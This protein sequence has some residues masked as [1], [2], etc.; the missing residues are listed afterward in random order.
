MLDKF[1]ESD[2][3]K[4]I[5]GKYFVLAHLTLGKD[6]SANPGAEDVRQKYGGTGG[7]PFH[8]FLSPDGKLIVNANAKD[9]GNIGYPYAPHEIAW[10]MEM[11]KQAAPKMTSGEARTIEQKLRAYKK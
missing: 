11:L 6:A 8:A 9:T 10:F 3:I 1:I 4:P 5:L 2:E 7:V